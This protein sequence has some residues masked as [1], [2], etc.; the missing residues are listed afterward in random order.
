MVK[1]AD[2]KTFGKQVKELESFSGDYNELSFTFLS[3]P[4]TPF[5]R[6]KAYL[7]QNQ[8]IANPNKIKAS[9][10][11]NEQIDE[12][13]KQK[14]RDAFTRE[15]LL[16]H[17][18]I[19]KYPKLKKS[20]PLKEKIDTTKLNNLHKY[21]IENNIKSTLF[22]KARLSKGINS[23][24]VRF[25][26]EKLQIE[27]ELLYTLAIEGN[28]IQSQMLL[29]HLSNSE[30]LRKE[31]KRKQ[32][33]KTKKEKEGQGSVLGPAL[34]LGEEKKEEEKK[35]K[36]EQKEKESEEKKEKEEEKKS[37]KR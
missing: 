16:Y 9:I 29:A 35:K 31:R 21:H 15:R 2:Y 34:G 1:R 6:F 36:E 13:E 30:K 24:E 32:M 37:K 8:E 12:S 10:I 7:K 11:W 23:A 27:K 19:K 33:A 17:Q 25:L 4:L 26:Q 3:R 5:V 18:L 14:Y 28:T 20:K 22:S